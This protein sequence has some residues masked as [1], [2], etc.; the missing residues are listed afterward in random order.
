MSAAAAPVRRVPALAR[1][2]GLGSV[3]A[4]AL[5][6][7]RMAT[8][9]LAVIVAAIFVTSGQ[10]FAVGYPTAESRAG[11]QALA[12]ELPDVM[13]GLYGNPIR[14]DTI[15]G[16][17]AWKTASF[18]VLMAAGW[19]LVALAGTLA[20]EAA[21][22]SLDLVAIAPFGKRRLALEKVAA[23]VTSLVLV[24][25]LVA[26]AAWATGA[27]FAV[28]PGDEIPLPAAVAF[29]AWMVALALVH[30]A[31]AFALAQVIGR[32][33]A[34]GLAAAWLLGGWVVDGY[35]RVVPAFG[36]LSLGTPFRWTDGHN[37]L[38]GPTDWASLGL[39]L[40]VAAVLL[41]LGVE[42]FVRRDIGAFVRVASPRLPG[43]L[44]GTGGPA[45]RALAEALP[46]ALWWGIGIGLW[47]FVMASASRAVGDAMR[48]LP[49]ETV[50][51][52]ESLMAGYDVTDPGAFLQLVFVDMGMVMGGLAAAT[53]VARWASDERGGRDELLLSVPV[54]RAA[55]TARAGLGLL[56]A[57]AVMTALFATAVGLGVAG[58]GGDGLEAGAGA[59]VLGAYAAAWAGVG[60]A[61]A[62]LRGPRLA[63]ETVVL[64]V[65]VTFLA[66]TL[67][68]AFDMP[69][70]IADLAL[71]THLGR[72]LVGTWD[73]AGLVACAGLA[74]GGVALGA[75][76]LARR[77]VGR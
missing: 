10:A 41:A 17:I 44:L 77:D 42:L 35:A 29:A 39:V 52:F 74:L 56:G 3:Y 76:G 75:A 27:A 5:R 32:G 69:G 21:R 15:P 37:P 43:F 19:S 60:V 48:S 63:A 72:P 59:A 12:E 18:F 47:G 68:P 28:I 26:L 30:G 73:P 66:A 55:M 4:K 24:G 6:D 7:G 23:H 57:I 40:A 58:A 34:V 54:S 62:G 71:S 49:A 33:A 70:W 50:A 53:F 38:V 1:V 8:L 46:G 65:V 45:R 9:V 64:L 14:I 22:G 31:L 25:V 51:I 16:A 36:T 13:A 61:I 67:A 20:G 11:L 2:W